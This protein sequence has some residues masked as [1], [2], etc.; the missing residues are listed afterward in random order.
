MY[1]SFFY[2][3]QPELIPILLLCFVCFFTCIPSLSL[4]EME[5]E[6]YRVLRGGSS[7]DVLSE[8]FG[9][10][11]TRKDLQTLSNLNWLN[12]EVSTQTRGVNSFIL[13]QILL[14][15]LCIHQ[16]YTTDYIVHVIIVQLSHSSSACPVKWNSS[17]PKCLRWSTF[18]WTCWSSAARTPACHQWIRSTLFS[19]PSC[20]AVATLLYAAGPKRWTSF[21]KTSCWFLSTWG[22]TGVSL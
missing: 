1:L 16:K 13:H 20:A 3:A 7:H 12:D 9:L 19:I 14:F 8:G 2:F 11:L 4:K 10:R 6:V 17:P 5:A 22:C 21:L 18:T 15:C